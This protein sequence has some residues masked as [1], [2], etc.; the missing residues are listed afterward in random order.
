PRNHHPIAAVVSRPANNGHEAA[1]EF[2]KK[3]LL[4]FSG[5]K[6]AG[7]LHQHFG[8]E[9]IDFLRELIDF[10]ALFNSGQTH[11]D[12]LGELFLQKVTDLFGISRDPATVSSLNQHAHHGF[13]SRKTHE[14]S[15][16]SAQLHFDTLNEFP[17][18][19]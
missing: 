16:F 18:A 11:A 12:L 13:G 7:R 19:F 3:S 2:R 8:G 5:G 6:S 14:G 17:V 10:L 15:A 4:D 9:T 1:L